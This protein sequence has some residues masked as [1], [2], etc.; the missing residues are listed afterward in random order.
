M[1]PYDNNDVVAVI[2]SLKTK[3]T[4]K[5]NNLVNKQIIKT[6]TATIAAAAVVIKT[7]FLNVTG[8]RFSQKDNKAEELFIL[9]KSNCIA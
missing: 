4:N 9:T 6:T 7:F 1:L 8:C 2:R 5:K 3:Q